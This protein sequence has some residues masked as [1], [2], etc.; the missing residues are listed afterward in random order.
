MSDTTAPRPAGVRDVARLAG[1]STQTV[2]R[3]LNDH[4]NIRP[5]TRARVTAAIAALDYR[6]NNAA[7]SLGTATSRTIGVIAW[8]VTLYGPTIGIGAL[9]RAAREAGRW[10]ATAY[11][12]ASVPASL[13][14]A[15]A[16]VLA[17]GIDGLILVAP[18][19]ATLE[20][21]R[22]RPLPVPVAALHAGSGAAAQAEGAAGVVE[23]LIALG[24][25]R[26]A[27]LAGPAQWL[28]ET[29][30]ADGYAHALRRHG[31]AAPVGWSGDWSAAS[32]AAIAA[33]VAAAVTAGEITA[34]VVANDQMALGLM[35]GLRGARIDVP[36]DV[37]VV[38]FDD[39]PDAEFYLPAL[40][41]V[42]VDVD[43]EARRCIAE[44][45]GLD[46]AVTAAPP[47][48]PTLVVRASTAPPA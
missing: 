21:L 18:H 33:D 36:R 46:P 26:I 32:G 4:P 48:P 44:V 2:S 19:A 34:V 9:E 12:D 25:R 45:L 24:H 7:R 14:A 3:V 40:T 28:E 11:A 6:V 30:R 37:S 16:H 27:R 35:A 22:A 10:I 8:D 13:D 15:I 39:N 41:T 17:Q 38:G 23:H 1:V 5:E 47:A 20:A 42:R 43:A 31:L 29:A